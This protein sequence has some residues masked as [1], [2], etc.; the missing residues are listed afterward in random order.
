MALEKAKRKETP[1][2]PVDRNFL[3][4]ATRSHPHARKKFFRVGGK[5]GNLTRGRKERERKRVG[6][7]SCFRIAEV[8]SRV[9]LLNKRFTIEGATVKFLNFELELRGKDFRNQK[10]NRNLAVLKFLNYFEKKIFFLR[11]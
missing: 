8:E 11:F 4:K 3:R 9:I 6:G 7:K 10:N 2:F 1:W 5:V